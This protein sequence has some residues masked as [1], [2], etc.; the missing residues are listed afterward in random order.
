MNAIEILIK[1]HR[2]M[3]PLFEPFENIPLEEAKHRFFN[4]V[5]VERAKYIDNLFGAIA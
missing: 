2:K 1:Q 4:R 5:A 3:E